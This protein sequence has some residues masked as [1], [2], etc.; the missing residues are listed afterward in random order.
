MSIEPIRFRGWWGDETPEERV[1]I[2]EPWE[3]LTLMVHGEEASES[4]QATIEDLKAALPLIL[5]ALD[6][7][8]SDRDQRSTGKSWYDQRS[9]ALDAVGDYE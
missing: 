3:I 5:A 7:E 2:G 8:K 4:R 1:R 6:A 9:A